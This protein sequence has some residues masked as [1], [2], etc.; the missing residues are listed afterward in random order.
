MTA[1]IV[2]ANRL[3]DG[4]V[5]YLGYAGWIEDIH[6]ARRAETDAESEAL[7]E[8]ARE[9]VARN[10]VADAWLIDHDG[11]TALRRRERIRALG[12]TVRPDL[13]YQSGEAA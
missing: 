4:R 6:L 7:L 10:E 11:A 13:G 12:P 5:V 2:T 3:D 9:G 8:E 1:R